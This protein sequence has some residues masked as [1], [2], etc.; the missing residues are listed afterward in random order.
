MSGFRLFV[1]RG[2]DI[3]ISLVGIIALSPFF[4]IIGVV[5]ALGSKGGIL[6]RQVRVG[7]FG[8]EFKILK[9]RTMVSGAEKKGLSIT[10]GEDTRI[11]GVGRFLRKFKLDELPQ[12]FNVLAGDMSFV[13][14]RPE[15]PYYVALYSDVQR[16]VLDIRPGMTDYASIYFRNESEILAECENPEQEYIEKIMPLKIKYNMKYID[17]I[18]IFVDIKIV[19]LTAWVVLGGKVGPK[20]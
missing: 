6:F 1:K 5:V 18:N 11:T 20:L 12:L 17:N 4:I 16:K 2:F 9:F 14:P 3:V 19:F 15:V 8:R 13:G 10:V 7:R